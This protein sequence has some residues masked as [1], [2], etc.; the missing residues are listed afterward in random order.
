LQ[1][2]GAVAESQRESSRLEGQLR[3][4]A[5]MMRAAEERHASAAAELEAE[6]LA[7]VGAAGAARAEAV[8]ARREAERLQLEADEYRGNMQTKE[9]LIRS[10]QSA[11]DEAHL[12][13]ERLQTSL[14]SAR[15]S[16]A[17]SLRLGMVGFI[18]PASGA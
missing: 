14:A 9:D 7:A 10:L 13:R 3:E 11:T 17:A 12:D 2:E 5:E 4:A 16:A 6:A 15:A 18:M 1:L 8:E